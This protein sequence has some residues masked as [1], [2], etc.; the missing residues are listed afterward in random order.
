[1]GGTAMLVSDTLYTSAGRPPRTGH[2]CGH[3]YGALLSMPARSE[4]VRTCRQFIASLLHGWGVPQDVEDSAVLVVDELAANAAE[5]GHA[6]M[7]VLVAL[8]AGGLLVQVADFGAQAGHQAQGTEADADEHGRGME[9][10][11][12]LAHSVDLRQT[13]RGRTVGVVLPLPAPEPQPPPRVPLSASGEGGHATVGEEI[14]RGARRDIY[15]ADHPPGREDGPAQAAS[16]EHPDLMP[17][18]VRKILALHL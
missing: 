13:A 17:V 7:T 15:P 6:D 10:V 4:Y 3:P 1:M 16:V 11:E 8:G 2:A 12:A 5:H 18:R 9:I 14:C